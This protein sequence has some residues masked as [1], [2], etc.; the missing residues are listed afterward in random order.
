MPSE[1]TGGREYAGAAMKLGAICVAR[2]GEINVFALRLSRMGLRLIAAATISKA[3]RGAALG[4]AVTLALF[5]HGCGGQQSLVV[6]EHR[7]P[8]SSPLSSVSFAPGS[9]ALSLEARETVRDIANR[10]K[11]PKL[12][13]E[14]I[15]IAGYTDAVGDPR[16]NEQLARE[17]AQTVAR[18]LVFNGIPRDRITVVAHGEADPVAPNVHADGSDN[19]Q[20][21]ALNRRV[22]IRLKGAKSLAADEP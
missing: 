5:L 3:V 18:E 13:H 9:A 16:Y 19:P 10:L 17:R 12:L 4:L 15:V 22:E 21:R 7:L 6:V 11:A 1:W 20:G 8:R 2:A 14:D